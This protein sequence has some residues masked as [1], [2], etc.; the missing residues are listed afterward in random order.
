MDAVAPNVSGGEASAAADPSVER[1]PVVDVRACRVGYRTC[2]E[3]TRREAKNFYYAFYLLPSRKKRAVFAL[4]TFARHADDIVDDEAVPIDERRRNVDRFRAALDAAWRGEPLDHWWAALMHTVEQ[5]AIPRAYFDGLI[6]GCEQ[7]LTVTRYGTLQDTLAYCYKV[8][9]LPGL[10]CLRVFGFRA[11]DTASV[12]RN[13]IALGYGMQLTNI[14]RDV[15]EDAGRDRIYVPL[16]LLATHG[17]NEAEWLAG[18][19]TDGI[20]HCLDTLAVW[21]GEQLT[22]GRRVVPQLA[23]D[24]RF[25]PA[26]LADLYGAILAQ[27]QPDTTVALRERARLSTKRKVAISLRAFV[28]AHLQRSTREP[29]EP[30]A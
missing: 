28:A 10:M 30:G 26:I 29:Q 1:G 23:R 25:C 17:V 6:D 8:A 3:T 7:D 15:R 11:E 20:K 5:F 19:P 18:V 13:G 16:D 2:R 12:E 21:A 4:Y 24:A 9:S 27:L 22:R 14:L